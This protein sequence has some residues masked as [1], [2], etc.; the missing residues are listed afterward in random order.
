MRADAC[1]APESRIEVAKT[2]E[3]FAADRH[4]GSGALHGQ[5]QGESVHFARG[6]EEQLRFRHTGKI[7]AVEDLAYGI[8]DSLRPDASD[9]REHPGISKGG[10]KERDPGGI[11]LRVVV[12]KGQNGSRRKADSGITGVT[13]PP[14]RL[15]SG[16]GAVALRD[17]LHGRRSG[18]VVNDDNLRTRFSE[19]HE[20]SDTPIEVGWSVN[21]ANDDARLFQQIAW[22]FHHFFP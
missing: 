22:D 6:F 16:S 11:S 17:F 20:R 10:E 12:D 18:A 5:A 15:R 4:A 7:D 1:A 8:R 2:I 13:K 3:D 14:A 19:R 21:G 9:N